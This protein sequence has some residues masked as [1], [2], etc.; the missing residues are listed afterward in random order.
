MFRN[1][2]ECSGMFRNVPDFIDGQHGARYKTNF[3]SLRAGV[4]A[5]Q[6]RI[7]SVQRPVSIKHRLRT[8]DYGLRTT[9]WL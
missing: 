3:I 2:P 1:V 5:K 6:I 7:W 9:D 8:T 4:T